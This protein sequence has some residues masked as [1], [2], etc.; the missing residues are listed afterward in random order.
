MGSRVNSVY[1]LLFNSLFG[2][3]DAI[4]FLQDD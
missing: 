1:P 4:V 2:M 3:H